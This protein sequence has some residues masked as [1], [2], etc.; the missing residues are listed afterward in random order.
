MNFNS[1]ISQIRRT[2]DLMAFVSTEYEEGSS[3]VN[4]Y[5]YE[6]EVAKEQG[7]LDGLLFIVNTYFS[8]MKEFK[9]WMNLYKQACDEYFS[10]KIKIDH[11]IIKKLD[12]EEK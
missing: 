7:Y 2:I 8:G 10:L 11:G 4:L 3:L 6:K 12:E 1:L 9:E 5:T